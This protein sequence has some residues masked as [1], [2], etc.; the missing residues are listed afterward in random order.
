MNTS[1]D[2]NE[3]LFSLFDTVNKDGQFCIAYITLGMASVSKL[4]WH[5]TVI[6]EALISVNNLLIVLVQLEVGNRPEQLL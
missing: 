1:N 5:C 6:V 2:Y 3:C 4:F